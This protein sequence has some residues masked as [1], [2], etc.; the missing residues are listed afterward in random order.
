MVNW[1]LPGVKVLAR[2]LPESQTEHPM[3]TFANC[4][5]LSVAC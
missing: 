1:T 4:K 3:I 5:M 2:L